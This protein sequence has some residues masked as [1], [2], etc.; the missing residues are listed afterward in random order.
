MATATGEGGRPHAEHAQKLHYDQIA[1]A[2][3]AHYDDVWSRRYR[4]RFVDAPLFTGLDLAG[5]QVLDAMCGSGQ[6]TGALLARGAR[7]TGLDISEACIQSFQ[8]RWPQC[9]TV[10]TAITQSGLPSE[11]FDAVVVVAGLHH[12]HPHIDAAI[13]EIHRLLRAGGMF[14]FLEPH[15]ASLADWFR[16]RWYRHDPLFLANEAAIDLAR[17]KGR[18]APRFEFVR[19]HYGGNIAFLLVLN[20]MVFRIPPGWKGFYSPALLRLEALIGAV[21]PRWLSCFA[22]CQWRKR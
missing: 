9:R 7:V 3:E 15:R 16:R 22:V 2:Y 13:K 19:E 10:C 4:E 20:S 14:C 5:R 8:S 17:L 21:Q 6:T 11:S 1:A 12:L 18:Y